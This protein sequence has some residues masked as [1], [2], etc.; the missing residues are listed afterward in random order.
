MKTAD[1]G[2]LSTG[3]STAAAWTRLSPAP[4]PAAVHPDTVHSGMFDGLAWRYLGRFEEALR[5]LPAD[6]WRTPAAQGW[7]AVKENPRRSVWRAV[8]GG[9][10]YY[11]KYFA[12]S[13]LRD[14]L[15]R[16]LG[17]DACQREWRGGTYA[18]AHGIPTVR[19]AGFTRGVATGQGLCDV[20]VTEALEPAYPL[21]EFSRMLQSDGDARRRRQD[22]EQLFEALGAMIARAH[23]AG[24]EHLD[25]HV[26]NVLVQ[27]LAPR[28]FRTVLLD[29]HSARLDSPIDDGAVVRNLA[30]LN[31]WFRRHSS[32]GDRLRFLRAYFRCRDDHEATQPHGRK[33][34]LDLEQLVRAMAGAADAHAQRLWSQRDRRLRKQ[35]R[36]FARLRV[37]GGWSGMA[38][39]RSKHAGA[40]SRASTL[41]LAPGWWRTQLARPLDLFDPQRATS[42]KNSHSAQVARALLPI[43]GGHLPVIAKRPRARNWRRRLSQLLPPSRGARGWRMGHALLHRDLPTARPLALLERRVGPLV[44]DSVLITEAVPGAVDLETYV[45]RELAKVAGAA[46]LGLRRE[47]C[48][49]LVGLLR[50]LEERG[51]A[52]RDCK[53]QN[54]LVVPLPELRLLWI[55]MDGLRLVRRLSARQRLAPLVRLY[56][57]LSQCA[58]LSRA[59]CARFLRAYCARFGAPSDAWK[60]LWRQIAVA[61]ERKRAAHAKRQAW[62]LKHYGRA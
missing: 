46:R 42:C 49:R 48:S 44:L 43:D 52:H 3:P 10:P 47:L 2:S 62:K 20:L 19:P 28:R 58:P 9:R 25:M 23:Q 34:G 5:L 13:G 16:T 45:T 56:V 51:V 36:Y 1:A 4:L 40:H 33:L 61:A 60:G 55:D 37:A 24:F 32:I 54:I 6:A 39:V 18:L 26:G 35:G 31:Q 50:R 7:Q 38:Y 57:S 53:A 11:A 59:D 30:Q 21:D 15:R 22:K 27:P 41:V 14:R 29:L 12:C 8:I 17:R